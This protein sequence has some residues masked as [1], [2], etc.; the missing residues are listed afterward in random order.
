M[1][2]KMQ[3]LL[4]VPDL[5]DKFITNEIDDFLKQCLI[6]FEE[7]YNDL[8]NHYILL[9]K[10]KFASINTNILY[11]F[12][13]KIFHI[14]GYDNVLSCYNIIDENCF[15]KIS[16]YLKKYSSDSERFTKKGLLSIL[17]AN[18]LKFDDYAICKKIAIIHILKKCYDMRFNQYIFLYPDLANKWKSV[19]FAELIKVEQFSTYVLED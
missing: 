4:E 1:Y 13:G 17:R 16:E 3:L 11:S 14:I 7:S 2:R 19:N 18:R 5:K 12:N 9:D 15:Y 10:I 8:G 6:Y